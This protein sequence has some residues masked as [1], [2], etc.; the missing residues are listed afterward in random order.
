M[1]VYNKL[2]KFLKDKFG[3]RVLKICI[4]GG[5]TCPN[6]DGKCGIGGCI[7]CGERGSGERTTPGEIEKQVINHIGSYRGKRANKYIAYFQ[8]FTNTYDT[9]ENLKTKYDSALVSD[10][11][12][13]LAIATRPDC[14]DEDVAK[15]ITSYKGKGLYVWVELGLQTVNEKVGKLINRGY[16]N[17]DFLRAV[18]ILKNQGIDVVTHIMLGLPEE[19]EGDIDKFIEFINATPIDGLK[20]HSTYVIKN[21]VLEKMYNEGKYSPIEIDDYIDKVIHI[22]THIK[23]EIV[24]HRITGDAPK[25]LL[26]TPT[27]TTHKKR[28]LNGVENYMR[29]N[30]LTQGCKNIK[31]YR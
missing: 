29:A 7:F 19:D 30:N 9:I 10:K 22:L 21:T 31:R 28:V 5:F 11:I 25:N 18:N 27:W 26:I 20:I 13:A 12:V 15:L 4:D 2:N 14:V 16:T 3:E 6:R 23:S 17:E 1:E 24:I 8:N